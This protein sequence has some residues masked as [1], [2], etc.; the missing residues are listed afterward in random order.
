MNQQIHSTTGYSPYEVVFKQKVHDL[1]ARLSQ[2]LDENDDYDEDEQEEDEQENRSSD[3]QEGHSSDEQEEDKQESHNNDEQEEDEQE[4]HSNDEQEED[5]QESHSND[6]QEKDKEDNQDEP[7]TTP[8]QLPST[9]VMLAKVRKRTTTARKQMAN[10]Y[11]QQHKIDTFTIGDLVSLCIPN[12]DRAST[13][14]RRIFCR[15]IYKP[16]PDRHQLYCEYGLLDRYYP[17]RELE[18]L[19]S[20]IRP[21]YLESFPS[22]WQMQKPKSLHEVAHLGSTG[23]VV[24]C[25]CKGQC[26]DRRCQCKKEGHLCTAHCHTCLRHH[27]CSNSA[28]VLSNGLIEQVEV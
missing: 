21:H 2:I 22:T 6:E 9:D 3:E 7:Q 14:H 4:G 11:L 28:Q 16:H 20:S 27:S 5:E 25:K 1:P 10:R 17:T 19:P 8:I 15:V 18:R 12:I 24:R 13:D 23:S 26:A